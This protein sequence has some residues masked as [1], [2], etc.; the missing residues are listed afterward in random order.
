MESKLMHKDFNTNATTT[1]AELWNDKDF[2]NVTLM[3]MDD[4]HLRANKIILSSGSTFF[5]NIFQRYSYENPLIY[6]NDIQ[7]EY[8]EL[9]IKFIYTGHCY[10]EE[11]DIVKFLLLGQNLGVAGVL[12]ELDINDPNNTLKDAFSE[13]QNNGQA[14]TI[15]K[16]RNGIFKNIVKEKGMTV[17]RVYKEVM[18]DCNK[19]DY[20]ATLKGNLTTHIK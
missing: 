1:F 3:T 14:D 8:L 2:S 4:K 15:N 18:Y 9:V 10:V 5:K 20:T 17:N 19:C 12:D 11:S 16:E 13:E 6:L 7:Y